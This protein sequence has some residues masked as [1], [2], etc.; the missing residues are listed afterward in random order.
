[1]SEFSFLS[2]LNNIPFYMYTTFCLSIHLLM[3]IWVVSTSQ[4]GVN[5]TALN[6]GWYANTCLSLTFQSLQVNAPEN[7]IV[8]AFGNLWF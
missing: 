3:H 7:G 1:M 6:S 8:G 4:A 2:W 5:K